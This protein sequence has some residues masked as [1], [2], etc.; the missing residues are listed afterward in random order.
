M[1]RVNTLV[2][3]IETINYR[4]LAINIARETDGMSEAIYDALMLE[5]LQ[6]KG[7][8]EDKLE[9]EKESAR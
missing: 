3:T 4:I 7:V 6:L 1:K 2:E 5:L 8:F 9:E